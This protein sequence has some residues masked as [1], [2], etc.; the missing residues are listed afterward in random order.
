MEKNITKK[1]QKFKI[2]FIEGRTKEEKGKKINYIT[3]FLPFLFD[4]NNELHYSFHIKNII[5]ETLRKHIK[6]KGNFEIVF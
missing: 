3:L 4:I 6:T 2:V 5:I 1:K